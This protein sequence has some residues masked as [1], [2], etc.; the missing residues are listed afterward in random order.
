MKP[1]GSKISEKE[2]KNYDNS[3]VDQEHITKITIFN[4]EC[5]FYTNFKNSIRKC[6][7]EH[8]QEIYATELD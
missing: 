1:I 8:N 6:I 7:I 5:L 3:S 2:M 4:I